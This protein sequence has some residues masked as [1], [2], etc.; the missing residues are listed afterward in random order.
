MPA[1]RCWYWQEK[2]EQRVRFSPTSRTAVGAATGARGEDIAINAIP[3]ARSEGIV[4]FVTFLDEI[5]APTE[6]LLTQARLSP[7]ALDR[8]GALFPL[9]QGMRF[10]DDA[11]RKQGISNIGLVVG[12]QTRVGD[13]SPLGRLLSPAMTLNEA[14]TLLVGVIGLF[15]SAL[16]LSLLCCLDKAFFSH[17]LAVGAE[18]DVSL[19]T[20]MLMIDLVRLAAGPRWRPQA[21]H[22]PAAQAERRKAHEAAMEIPCL[23]GTDRWTIVFD[24]SLLNDRL[25]YCAHNA[26]ADE[27][28]EGLRRAAPARDFCGSLRQVIGSLLPSGNPSLAAAADAAGFSLRTLQR[29]LNE[30]GCSYSQLLEEARHQAALRLLGDRSVKIVDVAFELGYADPANFTRAFRRWTG[31]SPRSARGGA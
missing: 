20:L 26:R 15:N 23:G 24:R 7:D 12:R 29:R 6:R 2:Q 13:L 4:P 31:T 10:L 5:G 9:H 3:L 30:A 21:I 25:R 27:A 14:I 19:F 16:E 1:C 8:P 17:R 22:V 18:A 28:L 11:A